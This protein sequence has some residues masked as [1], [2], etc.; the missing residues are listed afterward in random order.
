MSVEI[1]RRAGALETKPS[2]AAL[3]N[4][5]HAFL[6]GYLRGCSQAVA[7][8]RASARD[9]FPYP[10]TLTPPLHPP[11]PPPFDEAPPAGFGD[12]KAELADGA[13]WVAARKTPVDGD[14]VAAAAA[15]EFYGAEAVVEAGTLGDRTLAG[16]AA[17]KL[18]STGAATPSLGIVREAPAAAPRPRLSESSARRPPRAPKRR[19]EIQEH[20]V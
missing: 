1:A 19:R 20:H 13:R 9:A 4:T 3:Q 5:G 8:T 15:L 12:A 11:P 6:R 7:K 2:R 14:D 18:P 10:A 16:R 17:R